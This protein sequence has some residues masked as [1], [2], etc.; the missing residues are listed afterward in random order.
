MPKRAPKQL[1]I[2]VSEQLRAGGDVAIFAIGTM[3]LP[4]MKAAEL[5]DHDG[6]SATVVDARFASPVDEK[7][8]VG[9]AKSIGRIVT[10]EE[11]VP[12]G[13]FGSAVSEC[14]DRNG[15]SGTP[16]HRIALPEQFVLHGKRDELLQQVG[17]DASGIARRVLDWVQI[18]QRQ[19]T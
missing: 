11:N 17:L 10:I 15:L 14:L 19:Y 2:G 6:I 5:L 7:A 12:I 18:A 16:L 8:I 4:A 3:V 1:A 13:G 9:L